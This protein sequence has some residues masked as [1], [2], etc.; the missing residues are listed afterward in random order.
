MDYVE[1]LWHMYKFGSSCFITFAPVIIRPQGD[2]KGRLMV[3]G[4]MIK[5]QTEIINNEKLHFK[6]SI[7]P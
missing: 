7:N 1:E 5:I 4:K 3:V 2:S 6:T